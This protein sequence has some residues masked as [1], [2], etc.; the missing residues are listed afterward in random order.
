MAI[1]ERW[2]PNLKG[3]I[4]HSDRG[5]Q[6]TSHAYTDRLKEHNIETA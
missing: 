3:L 2:N 6:Y 5:V 1:D 4:H